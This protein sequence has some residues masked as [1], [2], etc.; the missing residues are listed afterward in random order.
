MRKSNQRFF[1]SCRPLRW[2]SFSKAPASSCS[3]S[4][5]SRCTLPTNLCKEPGKM[6]H[7]DNS[8]GFIQFKQVSKWFESGAG[9]FEALKNIDLS[10]CQGEHVAIVGKSGSGKSTLL[11]MLTG[12]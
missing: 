9:R 5:C 6:T 11:N 1:H 8:S 10:I 7:L 3:S 2:M 4:A 12:I